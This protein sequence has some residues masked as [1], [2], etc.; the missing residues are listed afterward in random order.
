MNARRETPF[1]L[2]DPDDVC[3]AGPFTFFPIPE[4]FQ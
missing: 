4:T 2:S 1:A 3:I